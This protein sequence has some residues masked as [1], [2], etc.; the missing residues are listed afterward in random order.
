MQIL[1]GHFS[2]DDSAR[3]CRNYRY[4]CERMT[5]I[6][7]GWI[8]LTPELSAKLLL[9]RHVWDSAQHADAWG[10]RLPELRAHA[11]ESLPPNDAFVAFM[12]AIEMPEDPGQTAERLA[13]I[14]RVLKPHLLAVYLGHSRTANPVYEPPTCR[15][16]E[17]CIEDERRHIAAG[18]IIIRHLAS[19]PDSQS[20]VAAWQARLGSLLGDAEGVTG[21]GLPPAP[22]PSSRDVPLSDDAGEF[23]RLERAGEKW[24]IPED[25]E[26]A[27]HA[28]GAA[29]VASDSV[30]LGR[31]LDTAP[32]AAMLLALGDRDLTRY[33][34]VAFAKLG[35]HRIVKYRLEGRSRAATL[36]ARWEHSDRGWRVGAVDLVK[37]E[38]RQPA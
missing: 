17:R 1:E 28:L 19:T 2:A 11:Q 22:A 3:L 23:I 12:D 31:F 21:Q 4:A 6:M 29:L 18:E 5:R 36:N 34:V 33:G 15:I 16:L 14:Y 32:D 10:R 38:Q 24:A 13:G 7:A 8:A 30:R 37:V 25:L 35:R 20:R 27:I 9:G 26:T